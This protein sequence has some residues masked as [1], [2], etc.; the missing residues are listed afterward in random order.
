MKRFNDSWKSSNLQGFVWKT[1][2][3]WLGGKSCFLIQILL[4]FGSHC[5][6]YFWDMWLKI[7]MFLNFDVLFQLLLTKFSKSEGFA[8]LQKDDHVT[9]YCK[10]AIVVKVTIDELGRGWT[11]FLGQNG[12]LR[13]SLR[14]V[15]LKLRFGSTTG[16][17]GN[18]RFVLT[19]FQPTLTVSWDLNVRWDKI[20]HSR[21]ISWE[22]MF[23]MF[24][25]WS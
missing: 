14:A 22:L 17:H 4:I 3:A 24:V 8:S 11:Q 18:P 2:Q 13:S 6:R 1:P 5:N 12:G 25:P 9:N 19:G 15:P 16:N 21:N 7:Y 20:F 23:T 10:R